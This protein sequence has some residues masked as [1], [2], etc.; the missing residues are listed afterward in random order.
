MLTMTLAE[1][2]DKDVL[3]SPMGQPQKHEGFTIGKKGKQMFWH[4]DPTRNG[5]YRIYPQ[6]ENGELGRPRYVDA[7]KTN[8]IVHPIKEST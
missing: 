5:Y 7:N 6:F 8:V 4:V 3:Y 1:L 2:I